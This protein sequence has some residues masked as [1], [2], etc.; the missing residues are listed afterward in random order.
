MKKILL[1]MVAMATLCTTAVAQ[2]RVK[3]VSADQ[4]TLNVSA[5]QDINQNVQ[6]SRYL[7][8]GYNTLCLPV[9]L[10]AEQMGKAVNGIKVERLA[11]IQQ[12][13]SKLCLYFIDCT[14][15]GIVA[16]MPYLVC[17]P[18]TQV[19]RIRTAESLGVKPDITPVTMIDGQGNKITFGSSWKGINQEGRYGIPAQQD[20]TPL[21]SVLV[22]TEADKMFLPTRCGFVWEEQAAGA[23]DLEIRHISSLSEVTGIRTL[24]STNGNVD[25]Y[26][27]SGNL[28][29]PNVSGRNALKNLPRGIYIVNG[30]KYMVQ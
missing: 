17:S 21:Q 12:E 11:A 1:L 29:R 13:G 25:V 7:F 8:A 23:T 4:V 9:S 2:N 24:K 15:E 26:D 18:T 3:N 30:E 14:N 27:M 19:M 5:L 10:S 22:R 20:V 6:L 28:V 16:G